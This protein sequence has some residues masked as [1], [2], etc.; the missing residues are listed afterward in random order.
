M[1]LKKNVVIYFAQ[2]G[3][4]HVIINYCIILTV[5]SIIFP[6]K[7]FTHGR[8]FSRA[9]FHSIRQKKSKR[10]SF[11]HCIRTFIRKAKKKKVLT[12]GQRGKIICGK[13]HLDVN[14]V[15]RYEKLNCI[16][17][18]YYDI[19]FDTFKHVIRL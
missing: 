6:L 2:F 8:S 7:F 1:L 15:Y 4:V 17:L 10:L 18:P 14:A 12:T 11:K 5:S 9:M 3:I 19:I 13:G 16:R